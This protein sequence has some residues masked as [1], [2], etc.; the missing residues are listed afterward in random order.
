M[1]NLIQMWKNRETKA[2]LREENIRLKATV[3][4]LDRTS[5]QN[6]CTVERNIQQVR[7][8]FLVSPFENGIPSEEYIKRKIVDQMA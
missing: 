8:S 7:T 5:R 4:A 3:S 6:I 1:A 2:K